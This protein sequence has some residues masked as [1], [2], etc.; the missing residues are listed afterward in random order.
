MFSYYKWWT[1]DQQERL[2][3]L[4]TAQP[5]STVYF[6]IPSRNDKMLTNSQKKE[7]LIKTQE[8]E[9]QKGSSFLETTLSRLLF[10]FIDVWEHPEHS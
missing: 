1:S 9:D 4:S 3:V 10:L 7:I 8:W 6:E 5:V 2:P